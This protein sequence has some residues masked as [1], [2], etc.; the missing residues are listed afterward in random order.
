MSA[1]STVSVCSSLVAKFSSECQ[2]NWSQNCSVSLWPSENAMLWITIQYFPN[3]LQVC[4]WSW[5]CSGH[6]LEGPL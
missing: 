3:V 5:F 4:E 2:F 6:L 1:H